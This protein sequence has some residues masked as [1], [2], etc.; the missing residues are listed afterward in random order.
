M[1]LSRLPCLMFVLL[2]LVVFRSAPAAGIDDLSLEALMDME[3]T[4]ASKKAQALSDAP[5]AI[6]VISRDDIRR[7]GV[8]SI[9]EA[10]RLVPGM[11]VGRIDS[12]KW[13]VASRGFNGRFAN[14]LL[15]MVDGRTVYTP[16]FSGVYWESLTPMLEDI[17]RI[18]VIR[19][20]GAALWGA[21]A[22]NG[23]INIITRHAADT[24]GGLVVF[25]GGS[26]QKTFGSARYGAE[27]AEGVYGRLYAT[28]FRRGD[29]DLPDGRE[30]QDD[31]DAAQSGFRVDAQRGPRDS[32][33]LQGD[34]GR[35]H[36]HQRLSRAVYA[37]PYLDEFIDSA[38]GRNANL[39][40]RWRHTLSPSSEFRLQI[41]WDQYL[42]DE[43]LLRQFVS[44]L[45]I[46]MQHS[47]TLGRRQELIWGLGAR[48][49]RDDLS[50][51]GARATPPARVSWLYSAF[52]QD[53]ILLRPDHLWLTL[54]VKL[55]HS[56][57]TGI[58]VQPTARLMWAWNEQHRFWA[59]VS[60]AVRTPS[61]VERTVSFLNVVIPPNSEFN[62]TPLPLGVLVRGSDDFVSEELIAWE[63][64]YRF[65]ARGGFSLDATLFYND[66]HHLRANRI[67]RT[68][69]VAGGLQQ[70]LP[71]TNARSGS[72]W[73]AEA[74]AVWQGGSW[75]RLDLAWSLLKTRI[76]TSAEDD[77]NPQVEYSPEHQL[78]LRLALDLDRDKRLDLWLRHVGEARALS[79]ISLETVPLDAYTTLDA[80]FAWR[81]DEHLELSL[82]ARDLF[83]GGIVEYVQESFTRPEEVPASY[84]AELRWD[85]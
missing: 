20:P 31:W 66:Y 26:Y 79:A 4:S 38:D 70:Q 44:T 2:T 9:P 7:A 71:F 68:A 80:R 32:L 73:G 10:L 24:Q 23:I 81:L 40:A 58:E 65:L 61:R 43:A 33:T 77:V 5:A 36:I 45:D 67:G 25:G 64:G 3:V 42:R 16:V 54:G 21:N 28:G 84:Y 55:E 12:N 78:S 11:H 63:L 19:G 47:F 57:Y 15:V 6:F 69:L 14:K 60:R 56:D 72:T 35:Q 30:G 34:I 82:V 74:A 53:E 8:R 29:F 37:P 52:A 27:L 39:L 18:E 83:G 49:V 50:G 76:D 75:W 51:D 48:R 85:F 1:N 59:S 22:V 41:Y 62:K 46:D 13:A 17:E